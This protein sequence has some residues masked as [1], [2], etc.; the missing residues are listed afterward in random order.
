MK[1]TSCINM[2]STNCHRKRKINMNIWKVNYS[3]IHV[4][5]RYVHFSIIP[6]YFIVISL[7]HI[8][9]T[10]SQEVIQTIYVLF[11]QE[12]WPRLLIFT[13]RYFWKCNFPMINDVCLSVCPKINLPKFL[14]VRILGKC[15]L[16]L[17]LENPSPPWKSFLILG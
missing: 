5:S 15:F 17:L 1:N 6:N 14:N 3:Y 4:C 11:S 13:W 7:L 16:L 9:C 8:I 2:T 12:G 10:I